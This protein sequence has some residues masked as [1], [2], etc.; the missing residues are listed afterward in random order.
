MRLALIAAAL[1]LSITATPAVAAP[2][3]PAT[4][5]KFDFGSTTSPLADGY[6][7]VAHNTLYTADLGYGLDRA[8][9]NRDRGTADPVTRDFTVAASYGFAVDVP[10]GEYE[11]KVI[12][13]DAIAPNT[14]TLAVEG[15]A[16]ATI[17]ASTGAYGD[18]T[19]TA[20]ITDGQLNL[21]FGQ[22]GRVNA[23][24]IGPATA[25]TGLAATAIQA[26]ATPAV[27]LTWN[28]AG[29]SG[30]EVHR[31]ATATGPWSKLGDSTAATFTDSTPELGLTY[32]YAVK[33][34]GGTLGA[35]LTV[36]V[37]DAASPAPATP[38]GLSLV[39]ATTKKITLRWRPVEN[40]L[41]Y[42][43][44]RDDERIGVVTDGRTSYSDEIVPGDR[45]AYRVVAAGPGGLSAPSAALTSPV[46]A[47]PLRRMPELDRGLVA[48]P[49]G[50]GTLV[51]WRMLGTDPSG[52]RFRLY[53]DGKPLTTT[54]R[55]N[56]LD[57]AGTGAYTVAAILDGREGRRSAPARPWTAA[58]LDIPLDKP[59]GGVTP[60]GNAYD[61]RA[62]DAAAADL[63]GDGQYEI[64]LKWDPSNSKD[65][66]Q[67]GYTGPAVFD[68][69][70][71]DGTR[72]WRV[73]LGRNVRA[74]AH[75]SP[76]LVDDFDGDGRAEFVVKT[77]DG[78]VDGAGTVIGDPAADH[79]T[80][81]RILSG[82]EY[83][84]VFDG[85]TGKALATVDYEPAR[86][87]LAD[88]GDSSANRSDRFLA[89]SA[90][91]DGAL[92][93]IVMTRGYYAKSMLVAYDWRD[94]ELTKRWT[95]S[96][97]GNPGYGGQGNH[98]LSVA[99]V[100]GDGRDEIAYGA[101]TLD[102]D[103]TGLYTTK[104]EHGDAMHLGDLDPARP[105]LEIVGVHEHTNMPCGL[106]MHDAATGEILWCVKTGQD[107]GRGL[108]GDIDPSHQGEEAWASNGAG[109]HTATGDLIS[110]DRTPAISNTIWWDGDLS[111]EILD[112]DYSADKLA[113][114]PTI[115]KW[116]PSPQTTTNLLTATGTY[117]NN[118]T[119]GNPSLQADLLGDWR[120]E[121]L[122]RTEDSTA[123]RLYT[124]PYA[125]EHRFP[126]L[127]HDPVYQSG[128]T[129]QNVGYNQPPHTGF[130]LGT[131]MTTPP[132]PYL[133]TGAPLPARV[134]L[135]KDQ[136]Q[137]KVSGTRADVL[138]TTVRAVADG[139]IVPLSAVPLRHDRFRIDATG[140][141]QALSGYTGTVTVTV[142]GHL[143]DG[144]TFTGE[145]KLR[146]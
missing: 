22:D 142:S 143:S 33:T 136:L 104:L 140:V 96:S 116:N 94:G 7:R 105:G 101:M 114:V 21:G 23:I 112:H 28:A 126:T 91:L 78:T 128:V 20:R 132:A 115:G 3:D 71:L 30:Y 146:T 138:P 2:P 83:L 27:T 61:Y 11:L 43:L 36:T 69:Y 45:H 60:A 24:L 13:G 29:S 15:E 32:S 119:K 49:T 100:D 120:E 72:L 125:T 25:P 113:G 145:V 141:E 31:A 107:T 110:A 129:W 74:G 68:A 121:L 58:Y 88:W 8:V 124:T 42:H 98:N 6:T 70:E 103:G 90:Y 35:P 117:S 73:D 84:T 66:S 93:S 34:P 139:K 89:A 16:R 109:L 95:F 135:H 59:A 82:P 47:Y 92:P 52:V 18:Y 51:S 10:N 134:Q 64:V 122:V 14:T 99:D 111:R 67:G 9:G 127:T 56:H 87:N 55:T 76:F 54:D 44:Y 41:L 48:V 4:G 5:L 65:N 26:T 62:N 46:T 118:T 19:G 144:R 106:E 50:Q 131:G 40:A 85:R 17:T 63:D 102:D 12:S 77:A 53:R 97:S 57:A 1:T 79:N 137:V 75:Y 133:T 108:T 80:G 39:T 130:F 123:L 37:K 81:G 86:G 38:E